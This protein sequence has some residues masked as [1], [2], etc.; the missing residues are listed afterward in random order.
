MHKKVCENN[1]FCEIVM[2]SEDTKMLEFNQY[3]KSDKAPSIIY[4]DFGSFIKQWMDV[5]KILRNLLQQK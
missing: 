2:P 4:K 5:K 1:Y 3:Q